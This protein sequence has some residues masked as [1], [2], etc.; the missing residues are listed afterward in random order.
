MNILFIPTKDPRLTNGGN[1]QRTNLLWESL[2]R[3]GTVYTFLSDNNLGEKFEYIDGR[4]PI[5]KYRKVANKRSFGYIFNAIISKLTPINIWKLKKIRDSDVNKVFKDIRFNLVVTRYIYPLNDCNYWEIAPLLI[6]IDDHP[7]QVYNTVHR[8]RLPLGLKTIG[9][10]V[11][12]W[13]TNYIVKKAKG[14][15]IANKDQVNLCGENFG[16]LPNIPQFPSSDYKADCNNRKNLFTVGAMGYGPNKVGVTLFLKKIWPS[17]HEKHPDVQYYIVGKGAPEVDVKFWNSFE[18]VKYLGFVD[19]LETLYEK[20]LATVVPVYSGGGTCIKTL[21]AMVH[22]RTC[23]STKFGARGLAED[24]V[25]G[26]K[27]ILLFEEA[28]TFINAYEKTLDIKRREEIEKL[29]KSVVESSYSVE[30]FNKAVDDI[31]S[32]LI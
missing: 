6:D 7:I 15:W 29:G 3:Y 5:Y 32:K 28:E 21:E 31:V 14:G 23:L 17:F 2:K 19:N 13:Q 16:F 1:E 8:K 10:Y 25:N 22:S 11:T 27:G 24:V 26:E 30:S 12:I 9:K 4:H 18:G 20:T